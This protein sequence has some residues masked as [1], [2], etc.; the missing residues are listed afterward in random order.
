MYFLDDVFE[1]LLDGLVY[2][3]G[4]FHIQDGE[5]GSGLCSMGLVSRKFC[6]NDGFVVF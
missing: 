1:T 6:C 3:S 5:I 4:A 2:E